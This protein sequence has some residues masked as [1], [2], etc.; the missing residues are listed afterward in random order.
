M[1]ELQNPLID[2]VTITDLPVEDLLKVALVGMLLMGFFV[3]WISKKV[4]ELGN[5]TDRLGRWDN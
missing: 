2:P 3:G 5:K 1:V 4:N